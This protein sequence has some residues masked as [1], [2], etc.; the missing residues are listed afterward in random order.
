MLALRAGTEIFVSLHHNA[1]GTRDNITNYSST[2]YHARD[3]RS[4]YHP[5]NHD[6]AR[7]I[8]RDMSY[9]MRNPNPPFS[10]TF[11]A[12]LRWRHDLGRHVGA[13]RSVP[14]GCIVIT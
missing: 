13:L 6:I 1:T 10:P 9:A 5:A 4:D 11:D 7:Y 2:Y 12:L 14:E 8:Q 3:G